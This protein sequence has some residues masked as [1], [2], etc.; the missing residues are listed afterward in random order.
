MGRAYHLK[1][2]SRDIFREAV[3]FA[4]LVEEMAPIPSKRTPSAE[5]MVIK[6][7]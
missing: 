7:F 2:V 4:F 5:E 1:R 3:K 6:K